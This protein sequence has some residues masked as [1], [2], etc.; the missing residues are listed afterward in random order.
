M[1]FI[2]ANTYGKKYPRSVISVA[3]YLLVEFNLLFVSGDIAEKHELKIWSLRQR[4]N[5]V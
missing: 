1:E 4:F 3:Y 5:Y 2:K